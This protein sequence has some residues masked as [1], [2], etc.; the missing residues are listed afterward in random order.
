MVVNQ[1][2]LRIHKLINFKLIIQLFVKMT[3]FYFYSNSKL[4]AENLLR[5]RRF[6]KGQNLIKNE[7]KVR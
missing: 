4:T 1:I 2:I 5:F 3:G 7:T 6:H